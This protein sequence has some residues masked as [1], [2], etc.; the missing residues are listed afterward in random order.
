MREAPAALA[1]SLDIEGNRAAVKYGWMEMILRVLWMPG[2]VA[3]RLVPRPFFSARNL[4]LRL[5]GATV[6]RSVHIYP[7]AMI[8]FP[9]CL[10]I[11]DHSSIGEHVYVYNLGR[12]VIGAR[13]TIS[14]KAHLCAGTHDYADPSLP[15]LRSSIEIE[16]DAWIC[17]DAFVGPG[18]KIGRGAVVGARAVAVRDVDKWSVVVGNPARHLKF[19]QLERTLPAR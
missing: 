6:G 16:D 10:A 12:V 13:A 8:Y 1:G 19:R 4:L 18:V 2:Q 7:S 17:A 15:L 9:W 11:G 5:F 3:F 14:H